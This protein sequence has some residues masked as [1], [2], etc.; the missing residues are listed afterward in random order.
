MALPQVIS[1]GL[2]DS[3]I[4][5]G[6]CA[7]RAEVLE[8]VVPPE[9]P[10]AAV[11]PNANVMMAAA[12]TYFFIVTPFGLGPARISDGPCWVCRCLAGLAARLK[13]E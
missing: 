10:Q 9:V 1:W 4:W 5:I 13:L 6:P 3:Q 7:L 2:L 11:V 12:Q 8:A